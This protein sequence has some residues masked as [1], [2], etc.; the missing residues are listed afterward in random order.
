[1]RQVKSAQKTNTPKN[2]IKLND[3]TLLASD[4]IF[5]SVDCET[6][7]TDESTI[8]IM[9]YKLLP[10]LLTWFCLNLI[11]NRNSTNKQ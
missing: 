4:D 3:I 6:K 8:S 5:V 11:Y 10:L 2:F 1:M 9:V 7:I